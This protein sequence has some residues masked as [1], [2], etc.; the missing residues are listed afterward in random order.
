MTRRVVM[1]ADVDLGQPDAT[2]VHTVEVARWFAAEGLEVDLVARGPD[3]ELPGVAYRAAADAGPINRWARA[4]AMNRVAIAALL[5]RRRG[6][7]A[8]Y[9]RDNP[10]LLPVLVAAR[11]LGY[12]V[13]T[14]VDDMPFGP[15]YEAGGGGVAGFLDEHVSRL[16]TR[17]MLRLVRGVATVGEGI[18]RAYEEHYGAREGQVRVVGNG[19]DTDLFRPLDRDEAI[20]RAGL[21]PG[22][23]YAV[24]VGLFTWWMDFETL[25]GGFAEAARDRP[26]AR[27]VLVGDGPDRERVERLAA[28]HGVA[29]RVVLTGFVADRELVGAYVAA[30]TVCLIGYRPEQR[31]RTGAVPIK[32]PEYLAAGRAVVGI[33]MPGV[34]ELLEESGGGVAVAADPAAVGEALR[35]LLDDPAR[36]DELGAA[37]RRAVEHEHTWQAVVRRT[38]PLLGI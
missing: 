20:R 17:L 2:R 5:R 18:R 30:A 16:Y 1:V 32:L 4:V 31:A 8:A 3:P 9:V 35:S 34:S 37:G 27:L 24:F 10:G 25:I 26:G 29:D 33:A 19:V 21:D 36:A 22:C 11:L 15:G 12:R 7:R 13:V 38:I 6:P 28:E 14:Q 23:R